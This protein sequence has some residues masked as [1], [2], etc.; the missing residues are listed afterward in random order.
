MMKNDDIACIEFIKE[1]TAVRV[2]P[3]KQNVRH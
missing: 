3:I 1:K 2:Q